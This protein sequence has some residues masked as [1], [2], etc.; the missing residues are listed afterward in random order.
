[1]AIN[2]LKIK[3]QFLQLG[4]I[5]LF[6]LISITELSSNFE[7]F[8]LNFFSFNF[9]MMIIYF[10]ITKNP[11]ILGIGHIF[12]AGIINDVVVGHPLGTSSLSYLVLAF[13]A[14]YIKNAT[15]RPRMVTDWFAF[16]P[17]ILL[18]NLVY[19]VITVKF[20]ELSIS[21]IELIQN[22]FFT[23]LFFPIFYQFFT[24]YN[25]LID[26]RENI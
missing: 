21:Y 18:S 16:I 11:D 2:Y 5:I 24:Y 22:S 3:D 26:N 10:W 7:N 1:M 15:L 25:K 14:T 19:F 13:I 17:A 23:F 6:Y 12:F 9:P 8:Y 4:P 20:S